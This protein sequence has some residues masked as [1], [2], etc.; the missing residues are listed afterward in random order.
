MFI[1]QIAK[2]K[3]ERRVFLIESKLYIKY[4]NYNYFI[5]SSEKTKQLI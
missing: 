4:Q 5:N 1:Y 3:L 2:I